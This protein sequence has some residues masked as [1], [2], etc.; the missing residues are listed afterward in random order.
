MSMTLEEA[1]KA[2]FK[3]LM[4]CQIS[5]YTSLYAPSEAVVPIRNL[6]NLIDGLTKYKARKALKSLKDDGV[7]CYKSQGCPAIE[8]YG[9]YRELVCEAMPPIN[10]YAITKQGYETQEWKDAYAD[11][12]KS[13]EEWSE[14]RTDETD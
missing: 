12:C 3:T 13:M 4:N 6:M 9:E 10:G 1:K 14:R 8:S 7:I 2:I 11:W 5:T